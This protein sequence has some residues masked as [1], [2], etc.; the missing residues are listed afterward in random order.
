MA[1]QTITI[2]V[3]GKKLEARPGQMLIEVTDAAGIAIPRFC[4][5]KKL[6]IAANCRMCLVEVENAPKPLPACATPVTD[7]MKV[8]TTS[9]LAREA[10]KGTMEFL[11]INHPLDCPICDQGGEC[12][13]QD[14]SVGYGKGISRFVEAKRAVPDEDIGPLIATC[15]TRCIH[16]TRCVRFGEEIAG[17]RELGAVG[18]GEHT[19]IGTY[20]G[21]TVESE[22]SGNV[23]DLCP[24]GALT[25]KPFRFRARAWEMTEH[26]GIAWHDGLGANIHVHTRRH[27]VMRVV[28]RENEA[29]NETWLSD[30]DRFSYQ[31]LYSDDRLTRPMSRVDGALKEVEWQQALAEAAEILRHTP[32]DKIGIL[33]SPGATLE[34]MHL[35]RRLAAGL[36]CTNLDHRLRQVDFRLE[37]ERPWLGLRFAELEQADG[38]L[39]IGTW[40]R[41]ESP[42]L[43]LRLRKA[44]E[45]GGRVAAIAPV[46]HAYNYALDSRIT[47]RPSAMVS[48]LAAVAAALEADTLGLDATPEE[49][50]QRIAG[51][52]RDA[53]RPVLMLGAEARQHPDLALLRGLAASIAEA[54]KGRWG[55]LGDGPNS[56][57][58]KLAGVVPGEGGLTLPQMADAGLEALLL[59]GIEPEQ[60][61][62]ATA[63]MARLLEQARVVALAS[64]LSPWL[65]AHADHLLP[66]GTGPETSGTFVNLQGDVQSFRGVAVPPGETRPGWKVL[67]VLGNLLDLD[68]FDYES[69]EAVRDELLGALGSDLNLSNALAAGADLQPRL[70]AA[71]L[72]R[73][74]GVA[75]HAVDAVTR[76]AR[77]LQATPD[78][79][80]RAV[81]IHPLTAADLGLEDGGTARITQGGR[82]V[83]M[84]VRLEPRVAEG[85]VWLPVGVPGSEGLAEAFGAIE[86]EKV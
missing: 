19:R 55:E 3:D 80:G 24:V 18:R 51:M 17:V 69:S 66:V 47:C 74:G 9:P 7:G 5:H 61:T 22:L 36:G 63:A 57:G 65:E 1:E 78:A 71:K 68:G 60:D 31:G 34:E 83:E 20:I 45:A 52:L 73:I 72:E 56:T 59:V 14:V 62:A 26:P 76:R 8:W 33:V 11:L 28:P 75:I 4:Y 6:S 42:L 44:V 35:A 25:S 43:N 23:I 49:R 15:M 48:E 70:G 40:L 53:E 85:C 81:R 16:C 30:R 39:L 32:A 27:Q 21:R 82:T 58:A 54:V 13:L 37:P 41:K 77:A 10:Q 2:E 29:V 46:T 38:V 64:H 84:P 79:W 86:M 12:E 67:R 50:H